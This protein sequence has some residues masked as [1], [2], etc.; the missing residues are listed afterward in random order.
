MD[1]MDNMDIMDMCFKE[2]LAHAKLS[3][4]RNRGHELL[5]TAP[6]TSSPAFFMLCGR[7]M[8]RFIR[9]DMYST[10][11]LSN[12]FQIYQMQNKNASE[13]H[14]TSKQHVLEHQNSVKPIMH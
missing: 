1:I 7:K 5:C 14:Q 11:S 6:L 4:T 9:T 13:H 12:V 10:F 3:A 2:L 8:K